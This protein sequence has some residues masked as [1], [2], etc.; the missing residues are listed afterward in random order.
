VI[1]RVTAA[2]RTTPALVV[3]RSTTPI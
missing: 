3:G 1:V 2:L